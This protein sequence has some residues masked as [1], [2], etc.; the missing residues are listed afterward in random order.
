[1][2]SSFPC[3]LGLTAIHLLSFRGRPLAHVDAVLFEPV[4]DP[5]ASA[6]AAAAALR[7]AAPQQRVRLRQLALGAEAGE[8]LIWLRRGSSAEASFL[9]CGGLQGE[10]EA[11]EESVCHQEDR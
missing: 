6:A 7:Q 9:H 11:G 1:M 8:K 2:A 10:C 3:A 4:L 5:K